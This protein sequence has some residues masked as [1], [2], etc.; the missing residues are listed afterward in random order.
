MNV[1]FLLGKDNFPKEGMVSKPYFR[2]QRGVMS[3][4]E[5]SWRPATSGAPHGSIGI[6]GKTSLL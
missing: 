1:L 6:Q 4:A 3:T 5:S 2:A